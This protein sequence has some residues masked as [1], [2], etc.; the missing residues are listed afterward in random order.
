VV[1]G[2][3]LCLS[4]TNTKKT[5]TV[6]PTSTNIVSELHANG[7]IK[8]G[9]QL[10]KYEEFDAQSNAS[11]RIGVTVLRLPNGKYALVATQTLPTGNGPDSQF[12]GSDTFL[13]GIINKSGV[14]G[15]T[16]G[17]LKTMMSLFMTAAELTANGTPENTAPASNAT[18]TDTS[19]EAYSIGSQAGYVRDK[20]AV[21]ATPPAPAD[22]NTTG[23]DEPVKKDWK[24]WGVRVLVVVVVGTGGYLLYKALSR[25]PKKRNDKGQY[26]SN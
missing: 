26:V 15:V 18:F 19:L 12:K 22:K 25:K 20:N 14:V 1:F 23:A 4:R 5:I 11:L 24:Y 17:P 16:D 6:M 9:E 10:F 3:A 7:V 13:S 21:V 2:A 8:N